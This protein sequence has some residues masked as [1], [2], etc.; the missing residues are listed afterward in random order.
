VQLIEN[1]FVGVDPNTG[2]NSVLKVRVAMTEADGQKE[3]ENLS[4][5]GKRGG[6]LAAAEGADFVVDGAPLLGRPASLCTKVRNGAA[7]ALE[8]RRPAPGIS[9]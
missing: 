7:A 3:G 2:K 4:Q 9:C 6:R 8:W 5:Y 1:N